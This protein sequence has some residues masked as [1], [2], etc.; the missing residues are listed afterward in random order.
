MDGLHDKV[1]RPLVVVGRAV[2]FGIIILTMTLVMSVLGAI[3][4]V[5]ALDSYRY[6]FDH[7]VWAAETLVGGLGALAGI[8]LWSMRTSK[9]AGEG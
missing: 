5:R 4:A 9:R 3:A 1:I 2:V 7:R 8:V 6:P